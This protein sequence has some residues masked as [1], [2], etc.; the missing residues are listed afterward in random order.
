M[1]YILRIC[2]YYLED[3]EVTGEK[4]NKIIFSYDRKKLFGSWEEARDLKNILFIELGVKLCIE[5]FEIG[6]EDK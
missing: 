4:I 1:Y 5:E 3:F 2:D 6:K